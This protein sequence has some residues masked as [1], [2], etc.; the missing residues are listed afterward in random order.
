MRQNNSLYLT[1]FRD[2]SA[3]FHELNIDQMSILLWTMI[4]TEQNDKNIILT[5]Y[6]KLYKILE[7]E[8]PIRLYNVQNEEQIR[9][10]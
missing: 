7:E 3:R 8:E 10:N 6:K 5:I 1:L 2:I 4:K 9:Q